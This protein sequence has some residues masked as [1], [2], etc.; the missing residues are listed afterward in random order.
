MARRKSNSKN[1][2][3]V[4][5][6][7]VLA[8][9]ASAFALKT[10]FTADDGARH[11]RAVQTVTLLKPPPAPPP[12]PKMKEKAPEPEPVVKKEQIVEQKFV[13]RPELADK[14][15]QQQSSDDKPGPPAGDRLGLDAVGGSGAGDGFG[16]AARQGGAA[17]IGGQT[18]GGGG[19]GIYNPLR[20]YAGYITVVQEDIRRQIHE[21]MKN[22]GGVPDTNCKLTLQIKLDEAGRIVGYSVSE[23]CGNRAM[24]EAV[25]KVLQSARISEPPP[26][27][28]PKSIKIR[29]SAKG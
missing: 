6:V 5:G 21:H 24:D 27:D 9:S 22:N 2:A 14:P 17:L 15:Q 26:S 10:L 1:W 16:L 8:V 7:I 20:K 28:M 12:P 3:V 11:Q 4:I 18:G 23:P 19:G 13:D 29:I 25:Q